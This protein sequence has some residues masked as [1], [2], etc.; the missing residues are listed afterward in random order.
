MPTFRL[1]GW[2]EKVSYCGSLDVSPTI[3]GF[4]VGLQ[5]LLYSHVSDAHNARSIDRGQP[6]QQGEHSKASEREKEKMTFLKKL[7]KICWFWKA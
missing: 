2:Y 5:G 6:Q 7:T 4:R 3:P 1:F